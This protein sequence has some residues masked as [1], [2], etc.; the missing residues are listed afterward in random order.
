[1]PCPHLL[2]NGPGRAGGLP[3]LALPTGQRSKKRC[4][5]SQ[6]PS[7]SSKS[8]W[9]FRTM[10][11]PVSSPFCLIPIL[12]ITPHTCETASRKDAAQLLELHCGGMLA[13][14][15]P[16]QWKSQDHTLQ[17]GGNNTV[18]LA[19]C[20]KSVRAVEIN[21]TLAQA[22]EDPMA[23]ATAWSIL[24]SKCTSHQEVA[25][26]A[27]CCTSRMVH[28]LAGQF[29]SQQRQVFG[30]AAESVGLFG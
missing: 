21:R 11:A 1:M 29:E 26:S 3:E 17:A 12:C 23:M 24:G 16:E 15:V 9:T 28:P 25:G 2:N 14:L 19:P 18:A 8:S 7:F 5:D 4:V 10:I 20:F 30:I 13:G 22:A 6:A 27:G